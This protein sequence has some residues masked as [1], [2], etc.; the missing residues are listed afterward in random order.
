MPLA[1]KGLG[2]RARSR[3][4]EVTVFL[5]PLINLLCP[6]H[7]TLPKAVEKL[8]DDHCKDSKQSMDEAFIDTLTET[9]LSV[10]QGLGQTYIVIDAFLTNWKTV[11]LANGSNHCPRVR[12]SGWLGT[13]LLNECGASYTRKRE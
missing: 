7:R 3:K 4:R 10:I 2:D 5:R 12:V 13:H 11:P 8:Y 9:L 6:I 1:G